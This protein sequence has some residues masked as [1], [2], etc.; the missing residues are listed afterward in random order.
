MVAGGRRYGKGSSREHAPLAELHAGMRLVIAESFERIYRQNADNI[1]L[2][3]STDFGLIERIRSGDAITVD[4]LVKDRDAL[5]ARDPAERRIAR[6][7][8]APESCADGSAVR[9]MTERLRGR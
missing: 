7:R 4:E 1:G 9:P 2:F 3:T 5:A 8:P 6:V